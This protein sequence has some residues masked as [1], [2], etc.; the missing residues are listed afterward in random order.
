MGGGAREKSRGRRIVAAETVRVNS[1]GEVACLCA[2][3]PGTLQ[4]LC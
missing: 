3:S 1:I 2:L 4:P